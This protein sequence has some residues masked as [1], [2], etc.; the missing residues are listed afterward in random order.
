MKE[1]VMLGLVLITSLYVLVDYMS[2]IK[3]ERISVES[4][5][6]LEFLMNI[7][8]V[9]GLMNIFSL[10]DVKVHPIFYLIA[11]VLFTVAIQLISRYFFGLKYKVLISDTDEISVLLKKVLWHHGY[12]EVEQIVEYREN[13]FSFPGE[14][15]SIAL[16]FKE[17][18]IT[19]KDSHTL[20]FKKWVDSDLRESIVEGLDVLL[21]RFEHETN[22]SFYKIMEF[23]MVLLLIAGC[24]VGFN[25]EALR[26][27]ERMIREGG[28]PIEVLELHEYNITLTDASV[29]NAFNEQLL[30]NEA[31]FN[32]Y[33]TSHLITDEYIKVSFDES[34]K[35]VYIG[36]KYSYLY[37]DYAKLKEESII[38]RMMVSVYELYGTKEGV[39]YA[40][41]ID[42]NLL[43]NRL[44]EIVSNEI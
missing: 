14:K 19:K 12:K 33:V 22:S 7:L 10:L 42:E 11:I 21:E 13:K 6:G 40:M 37:I 20:I 36:P 18:L 4:K 8:S 17:G 2:A 15:K 38:D 1:K 35:T 28:D 23:L 31:Y 24:I 26:P 34:Y 30:F 44:M 39:Y 41:D 25:H 27:S 9:L 16:V 3:Y 5:F 43:Y 32:N 29:L